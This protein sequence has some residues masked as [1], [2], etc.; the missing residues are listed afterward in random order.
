MLRREQNPELA[1][2]KCL[3]NGLKAI[4]K[5]YSRVW[6]LLNLSIIAL[7]ITAILL[8]ASI[9]P[10]TSSDKGS[11][12]SL[13][14]LGLRL[15]TYSSVCGVNIVLLFCK[16]LKYLKAWSG[17]PLF[18]ALSK[19]YSDM[20]YFLILFF[21]IFFAFVIMVNVY[22]GADLPAFAS[23]PG[24]TKALFLM[25]LGD[26]SHLDAMKNSALS[27]AFFVLFLTS[28]HFILLNM[29]IAFISKSYTEALATTK[30]VEE[31]PNLVATHW[32]VK[33]IECRRNQQKKTPPPKVKQEE[34]VRAMKEAFRKS[35]FQ[36]ESTEGPLQEAEEKVSEEVKHLREVE[37]AKNVLLT[38]RWDKAFDTSYRFEEDA[39]PELL[40]EKQEEDV[41]AEREVRCGWILWNSIIY[42]IY[43]AIY[44]VVIQSQMAVGNSYLFNSALG[45]FISPGELRSTYQ[46]AT[47]LNSSFAG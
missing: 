40:S 36:N 20:L 34:A 27:I 25:L 35:R 16:L 4:F 2:A 3:G 21:V 6:S 46:I 38:M 45:T 7:S 19:A 26:L 29:I 47:W 11:T 41:R 13:L 9:A 44:M 8:W 39:D 10:N 30:V 28:M 5:H 15:R 23:A 37:K 18:K 31:P 32:T 22:Y 17:S 33:L 43:T 1:W 42:L 24:A 14:T 12:D